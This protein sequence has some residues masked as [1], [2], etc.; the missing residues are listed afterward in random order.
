MYEKILSRNP[1]MASLP[2]R[3]IRRLLATLKQLEFPP[4]IILFREGDHGDR[5]YLILEG[6][7][8]II[9][10]LGTPDEHLLNICVAGDYIGEMCLLDPDRLRTASVRTGSPVKLLEMTQADLDALLNEYPSIGYAM[11]RLLSQRL[12]ASETRMSLELN[13]KIRQLSQA[14]SHL[15]S[16]LPR[17]ALPS[18]AGFP[19]RTTPGDHPGS[20]TS[21]K[22][23]Q[24][25]QAI[26]RSCLCPIR[27]EMFGRFSLHRGLTAIEEKEWDGY[28]PRLL[29]KA[30]VAHGSRQ[31]PKD[32][33]IEALW[34]ETAPSS[35]EANF[36]V[37]LHR[38][39]KSLEPDMDKTF[40][41]SY[42]HLKANAISLNEELCRT[43][44]DDFLSLTQRGEQKERDGD[45]GAAL[46][47]YN[48]AI[49]LYKGDFLSEELYTS[50]IDTKRNELRK[51]YIHLLYKI[52]DIQEKRGTSKVSIDCYRK[53]IEI[54]PLAEQVYRRLMTL[55]AN[56]GRR[57]E[58]IKL[59]HDCRKALREGLDA[60]PEALTTSIYKKIVESR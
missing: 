52:A 19:D 57:T 16:M 39:R 29:L 37:T 9:K 34:P 36:K 2:Q 42:V 45:S 24:V 10:A 33:L 28:L 60:E 43:D 30:I 12:E 17:L 4:G 7:L 44:L 51:Q 20:R 58:A 3:E 59:Y 8:E 23:W 1:L 11:A 53:I 40:G 6:Q 38:L 49:D 56:K 31:V 5:L 48:D 14:C 54:D 15:Q 46:L 21:R 13:T 25:Q 35:G 27:I 41:S 55:F 47:L 18:E 50:W 22:T 32:R 26:H